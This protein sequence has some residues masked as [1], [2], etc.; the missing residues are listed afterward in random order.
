[1]GL[2]DNI[3]ESYKN[4]P[5]EQTFANSINF[6]DIDFIQRKVLINAI[7][8]KNNSNQY[9]FSDK[10]LIDNLNIPDHQLKRIESLIKSADQKNIISPAIKKEIKESIYKYKEIT[11]NDIKSIGDEWDDESIQ[12]SLDRINGKN[13]I[14]SDDY[15]NQWELNRKR[16]S[17]NELKKKIR[18]KI[19][20]F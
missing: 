1:M 10:L 20:S 19:F 3:S 11:K 13:K 9:S 17:K 2:F 8:K 4:N 6:Q 16:K 5:I 18:H 12:Q 14:I 7:R 15:K